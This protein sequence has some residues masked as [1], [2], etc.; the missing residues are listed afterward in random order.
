MKI[1]I[2]NRK[3]ALA[4]TNLKDEALDLAAHVPFQV[5]VVSNLLSLDRDP[6]IRSLTELNTRELRVLLNVGSYGPI[7]AAEVSY[8]SRLDPYSVTRAVNVLLKLGLVQSKEITG[9]S[10][11]VVLTAEGE[12]IYDKVTAHVRKREDMLTAHMTKDEKVL[13]ETLLMKLE[14]T[15]EEILANEVTE[16]EAQG[17]VV[18]RDHKEML[19]WHKRSR[20]G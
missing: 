1:A 19:R 11:P 20:H 3:R 13:L 15:A 10:K 4:V 16:M 18:T 5:A 7:T 17:Q 12:S 2:A 9:K 14:L 6:V 8:Q